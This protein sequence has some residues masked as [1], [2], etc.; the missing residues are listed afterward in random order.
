MQRETKDESIFDE[1]VVEFNNYDLE[2][3]GYIAV[4]DICYAWMQRG[5]LI[6]E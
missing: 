3:K 2:G 4:E 5:R 6:T 1:M